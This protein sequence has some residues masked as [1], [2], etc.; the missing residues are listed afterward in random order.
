MTL[1]KRQFTFIDK[2]TSS[3]VNVLR[4]FSFSAYNSPMVLMHSGIGWEKH[5]N[6]VGIDC[7]VNLC[8][9]GENLL[10]HLL[11]WV[12]FLDLFM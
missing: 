5:L 4:R 6:E 12:A 7:K 10:D 8:G 2:V 1:W 11:V 3:H 9:V